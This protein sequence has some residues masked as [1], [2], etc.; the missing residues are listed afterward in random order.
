M[1]CCDIRPSSFLPHG[2]QFRRRPLRMPFQYSFS[3]FLLSTNK[4]HYLLG[5]FP[6]RRPSKQILRLAAPKIETVIDRDWKKMT[7]RV[8]SSCVFVFSLTVQVSSDCHV[9]R[10]DLNSSDSGFR[11]I[12][13]L[14]KTRSRALRENKHSF[15]FSMFQGILNIFFIDSMVMVDRESC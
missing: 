4:W 11:L 8:F 12:C 7:A 15:V 5:R 3:L 6:W 1:V 13:F 9:C 2:C 14:N 10:P